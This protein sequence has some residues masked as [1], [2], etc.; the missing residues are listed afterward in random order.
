MHR[1]ERVCGVTLSKRV[2]MGRPGKVILRLRQLNKFS[3]LALLMFVGEKIATIRPQA[4]RDFAQRQCQRD[5][6]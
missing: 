4:R 2:K 1:M 3:G 6:R 5:A